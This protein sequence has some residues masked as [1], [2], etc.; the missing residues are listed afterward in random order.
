MRDVVN[1]FKEQSGK[2]CFY[3]IMPIDNIPSVISRGILS[4]NNCKRISHKS[5]ASQSVQLIRDK[6]I[7]PNGMKLHDYANIY[8]D[9]RNPMMYLI[10]NKAK[11]LCILVISP[12]ILRI[13][14]VV[15]SDRNASSEYNIFGDPQEMIYNNR[16]DYDIIYAE[17]WTDNDLHIKMIKKSIKCAEVLVPYCIGYEYIIGAYVLNKDAEK[18]L[19]EK[20]FTEQ[21][22]INS[23]LF[24]A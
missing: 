16:L 8:F 1:V 6:V 18:E 17:Y 3:S 2:V 23:D 24:F 13:E 7:I 9:C 20:G 19:L 11:K 5:V 15:V 12:E 22:K 21:I 10:K 14:G 4:H